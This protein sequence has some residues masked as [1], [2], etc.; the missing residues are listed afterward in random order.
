MQSSDTAAA[1]GVG[2]TTAATVGYYGRTAITRG[3]LM[4][5]PRLMPRSTEVSA[6]VVSAP[7]MAQS[8][9][10]DSFWSH[11]GSVAASGGH[12]ICVVAAMV[13]E[14]ARLSPR[15]TLPSATV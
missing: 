8:R 5:S 11:S 4:P 7:L 9:S 13:S 6:A 14:S 3:L 15:P 10:E 2:A 12:G 1:T